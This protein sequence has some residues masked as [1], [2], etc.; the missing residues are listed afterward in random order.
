MSQKGNC[1][2]NVVAES[3]FWTIGVA[4]TSV[5]KYVGS[6]KNWRGKLSTVFTESVRDQRQGSLHEY[7]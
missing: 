7:D 1:W 6:M 2:D 4:K 3:F 5:F